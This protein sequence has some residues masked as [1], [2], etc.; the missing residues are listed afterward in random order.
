[1]NFNLKS[2]VLATMAVAVLLTGS[3]ASAEGS[4]NLPTPLPLTTK[5]PSAITSTPEVC[6][7]DGFKCGFDGIVTDNIWECFNCCNSDDNEG[8]T[9]SD[10]LIIHSGLF[11][12]DYYC[13]C[14]A[15]SSEKDVKCGSTLITNTFD[16]CEAKCCSGTSR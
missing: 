10:N 11:R 4:N 12:D 1:M 8:T 9:L 7:G 5:A 16:E 6:H 14:Y 3:A 13:R 2:S 15:N